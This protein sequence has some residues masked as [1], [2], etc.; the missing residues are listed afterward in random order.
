MKQLSLRLFSHLQDLAKLL[1][2]FQ[3]LY[4]HSKHF[5]FF[6]F[7]IVHKLYT[8]YSHVHTHRHMH[9]YRGRYSSSIA[10]HSWGGT[11]GWR[12]KDKISAIMIVREM[13][14]LLPRSE[15]DCS[16]RGKAGRRTRTVVNLKNIRRMPL[17]K[18]NLLG[19]KT[20]TNNLHRLSL[21]SFF[22]R[23][24]DGALRY[25][26]CW[27]QFTDAG[28]VQPSGTS[29]LADLQAHCW[30]VQHTLI[31]TGSEDLWPLDPGWQHSVFSPPMKRECRL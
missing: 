24:L 7:N 11:G 14:F 23:E 26:A 30:L 17:H 10:W 9:T 16:W 27:D 12:V 25:S 29:A 3:G 22:L 18:E 1:V 21:G 15:V 20:H 5:F 19:P 31:H 13:H 28:F 2:E 6:F 8:P 4:F